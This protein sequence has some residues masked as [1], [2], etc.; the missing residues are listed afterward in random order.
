MDA[1]PEPLKPANNIVHQR[2]SAAF[3]PQT[4]RTAGLKLAQILADHFENVTSGVKPTVHWRTPAENAV[5]A[6][7][8][9]IELTRV[10]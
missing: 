5:A 4:I 6:R 7:E 1:H 10:T 9:W 2:I 3:S 8:W